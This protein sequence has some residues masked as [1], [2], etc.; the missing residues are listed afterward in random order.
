[1]VETKVCKKCCEEKSV[2][3][4][5][6][7]EKSESSVRRDS[8]CKHCVKEHNRKRYAEN[9]EYGIKRKE[10]AKAYRENPSKVDALRENGRKFYASVRG[11]AKTL[12]KSAQ[13]RSKQYEDFDV[14][15][16]WIEEKLIVGVCEITG[17]SFDF[18]PHPKYCKNPFAPSIDRK[19]S[20]KGYTRDNVRIVLWQV[21]LM[22]GEMNDEEIL[23]LCEDVVRGLKDESEM[24]LGH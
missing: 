7:V 3:D 23:E 8:K 24:D 5:Y 9:P 6:V 12:F 20:T 4:F 14:T 13:R 19:D 2:E 21:N 10:R 17:R 16:E 18:S 1:M 15:A 11:R 22:R